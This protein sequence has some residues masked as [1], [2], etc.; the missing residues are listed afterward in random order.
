MLDLFRQYRI[1]FEIRHHGDGQQNTQGAPERRCHPLCAM[2][3][4]VSD[5]VVVVIVIVEI[6]VGI[7][8]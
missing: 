4:A 1:E 2:N 8:E 3:D 5:V 7:Y 6:K